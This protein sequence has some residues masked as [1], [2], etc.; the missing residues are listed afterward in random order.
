MHLLLCRLCPVSSGTE[1]IS[2]GIWQA[3]SLDLNPC[4]LFF[5]GCLKG[6]FY[7]SNPQMKELKKYFLGNLKYS[8]RTAFKE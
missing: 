5:W 2:L 8:R 4:D 1:L 6:K 3:R 7:N